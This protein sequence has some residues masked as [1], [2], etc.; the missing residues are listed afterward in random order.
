MVKGI[1]NQHVQYVEHFLMNKVTSDQN[2]QNAK[3]L[4]HDTGTSLLRHWGP[5]TLHS[6]S[7]FLWENEVSQLAE[8]LGCADIPNK[9]PLYSKYARAV[10]QFS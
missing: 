3:A 7:C 5:L 4:R 2:D 6:V 10:A 8:R 9:S 1:N